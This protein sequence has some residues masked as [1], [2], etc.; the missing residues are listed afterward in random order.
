LFKKI[1]L[2][3]LLLLI[4]VNLTIARLPDKP[5]AQ[6]KFVDVDGLR[7]HYKET[8]GRGVPVVMIHGMPGT[9]LDW[10]EVMPKL[11]GI[12]TIAIDRPGYGWSE[13]GWVD[14]Q[15]QIDVVYRMLRKLGVRRAVFAG[16]SFG[17]TIT[18]GMAREHPEIVSKMV[19]VAPGGGER[20]IPVIAELQAYAVK[21]LSVPVVEQIS[22]I[23]FSNVMRRVS[24]NLGAEQAFAPDPVNEIYKQRLLAVT[25]TDGNLQALADDRLDFNNEVGPWVDQ[26]AK[27]VRTRGVEIAARDDELVPFENAKILDKQLRNSTLIPVSGGHMVMY[28]HPDV[29]AREIRKAVQAQIAR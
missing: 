22:D 2:A 10:Q 20:R 4:V 21:A 17:G 19:L 13:G 16:H 15:E 24:A 5:A 29:V 7:M 12:R 28:S 11:D 23:V 25:M 27:Q 9:W 3:A 14:Y 18:I 1:L 6:G 26:A 8:P